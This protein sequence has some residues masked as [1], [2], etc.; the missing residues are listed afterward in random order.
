MPKQPQAAF[1][2]VFAFSPNRET[3]GGTSYL[4]LEN[5]ALGDASSP[6]DATSRGMGEDLGSGR[7]EISGSEISGNEIVGEISGNC[8][9]DCPPWTEETRQFLHD[10]GGVRWLVITHRD[11]IATLKIVREIQAE[12]KCQVIIQEQEAYLLPSLDLVTFH[13]E[14]AI[15]PHLHLLWT[16]GYS[17]G[18]SCLHLQRYGGVLFSGRHLLPTPQGQLRPHKQPK[19][20][21]WIR[22]HRSLEMLRSRFTTDTLNYCCPGASI[23]FLRGK[24]R[25][26]QAY[27][28]IC[29]SLDASPELNAQSLPS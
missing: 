8:L 22:Q 6:M 7:S 25:I 19:T 27:A 1:E 23:G 11:A 12:F 28:H 2:S 18:S 16:P 4:I 5:C 3:A 15:A 24:K 14:R 26:D 9:V 13:Q 21:H 17:P 10:R 20:F 29:A